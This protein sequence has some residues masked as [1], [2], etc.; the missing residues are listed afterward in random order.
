MIRATHRPATHKYQVNLNSD[1]SS[2]SLSTSRST[3]A[4]S[5]LRSHSD[6]SSMS[7]LRSSFRC[8]RSESP[9]ASL[10]SDSSFRNSSFGSAK[11]DRGSVTPR[12]GPFQVDLLFRDGKPAAGGY[13]TYSIRIRG[14]DGERHVHRRYSCF[15]SLRKGMLQ[16]RIVALAGPL[17]PMPPKSTFRKRF[18]FTKVRFMDEREKGL[19]RLIR[20]AA[21]ADPSAEDPT[22]R[23]FLALPPAPT[24]EESA[25]G[26]SSFGNPLA[27]SMCSNYSSLNSIAELPN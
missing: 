24:K 10:R 14:A 18:F 23:R 25:D 6:S 15:Q 20:A 12:I 22:W 17:P 19:R 13:A 4:P 8:N 27:T 2:S 7:T 9:V 5:F 3:R 1:R 11:S 26:R 21:A 16:G